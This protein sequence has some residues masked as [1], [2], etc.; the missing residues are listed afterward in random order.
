VHILRGAFPHV[1]G[2]G[3]IFFFEPESDGGKIFVC[4]IVSFTGYHVSLLLDSGCSL[5]LVLFV[6]TTNMD[7]H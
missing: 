7:P 5:S 1:S 4:C 2:A 6:Q 3:S